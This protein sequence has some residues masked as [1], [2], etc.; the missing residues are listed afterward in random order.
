MKAKAQLEQSMQEEQI[1]TAPNAHWRASPAGDAMAEFECRSHS[2]FRQ[3]AIQ[4]RNDPSCW[5]MSGSLFSLLGL[6]TLP[7]TRM[8]TLCSHW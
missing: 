7:S 8:S 2:N 4:Q 3:N 6:T 1:R 5:Q